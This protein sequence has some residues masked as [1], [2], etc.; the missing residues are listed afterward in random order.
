MKEERGAR[1]DKKFAMMG[2]DNSMKQYLEKLLQSILFD[3][4]IADIVPEVVMSEDPTHGE[5]STNVAL[6]IAGRMKKPAMNVAQEIADAIKKQSGSR[7]T[8]KSGKP[9]QNTEQKDQT[10]SGALADVDILQAIDR[11]ET[12]APGFVNFFLSE[13]SLITSMHEV[14]EKKEAYGTVMRGAISHQRSVISRERQED[15]DGLSRIVVEFTD[16]NPFKEFHIGHLYSNSVGESL[17]RLL[18]SQGHSVRR[19]CYQGDVGLHVAKTL[20]GILRAISPDILSVTLEQAQAKLKNLESLP[21]SARIHELGQAYAAGAAAYEDESAAGREA[22]EVMKQLNR[23][24]FIAGQEIGKKSGFT[25]VVDYGK[26]AEIDKGLL[27]V[28]SAIYEKGRAWSLAYFETIYQRL[29][30]RFDAYYFESQVGEVGVGLV[31]EFLK[32]GIFEESD[33]AVIYKGEKKGLHTRVFLN[34]LGLPTYEAKELG[35]APTKDKDWPYDRSLIVTGNEINEYFKVL[36]AALADVNPDLAAKTRHIGHGMVRKSDGSKMSSRSGQVLTG[37]GLLDE[38]KQSI[39]TILD[40][41]VSPLKV[42]PLKDEIAE[43]GAVAAVKYSLLRVSLPSD[44][45]FDIE[46]S[47]SFDGDSGPYLLYTYARAKSVLRKAG[48]EEEGGR[49]DKGGRGGTG[50]TGAT[51]QTSATS[52][53]SDTSDTFLNPVEHALARLLLFFPDITAEAARTLSPSLLCNYLFK[54]AQ[55]FNGFYQ[56]HTILGEAENQSSVVSRQSSVR[57]QITAATAHVLARGLYLLG[58]RTVER[59]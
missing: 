25:P 54:L 18:E 8:G 7:A 9:D 34:K 5:Y 3:L 48:E 52:D 28:V 24:I 21:L 55:A 40:T 14:L 31:G 23:L 53:T 35:L 50:V 16:P 49:G 51:S 27:R 59:M 19:V 57:L 17:S 6:R 58:I 13:A 30:T 44:V 46:T 11:V 39:Y 1:L 41:S 2:E 4:G 37:E 47:I 15:V 45:S 10:V 26:N 56:K 22:A 42:R 32:K 33:G 43:A 38:V 20:W 36:L 29:G 12:A